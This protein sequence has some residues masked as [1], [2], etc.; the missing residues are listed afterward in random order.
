VGSL[1]WPV[2]GKASLLLYPFHCPSFSALHTFPTFM[3]FLFKAHY[4]I[5]NSVCKNVVCYC[6]PFYFYLQLLNN[7]IF[8]PLMFFPEWNDAS[9]LC[10]GFGLN[11]TL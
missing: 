5:F 7:F 1:T 2:T 10:V 9:A 11:Y 6:V 4:Q 8:I 3:S